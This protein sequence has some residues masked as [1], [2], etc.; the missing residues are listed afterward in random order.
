MLLPCVLFCKTHSPVNDQPP[1]YGLSRVTHTLCT[2]LSMYCMESSINVRPSQINSQS[3]TY[4]PV[5]SPALPGICARGKCAPHLS[6]TVRC[7]GG[8]SVG[9][10]RSG[11]GASRLMAVT[12]F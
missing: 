7:Q 6:L 2:Y 12:V 9:A 8:A 5:A 1:N 4:P 3:G 11:K 10:L